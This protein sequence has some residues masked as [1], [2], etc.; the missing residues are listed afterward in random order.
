[1]MKSRV[2]NNGNTDEMMLTKKPRKT[3][4][5]WPVE[6]TSPQTKMREFRHH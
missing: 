6:W 5:T 3:E 1:M 2:V 4:V